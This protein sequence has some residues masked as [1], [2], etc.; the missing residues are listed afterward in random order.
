MRGFFCLAGSLLLC[1]CAPTSL[2]Q[3]SIAPAAV[4]PSPTPQFSAPDVPEIP[5]K[6]LSRK[7]RKELDSSL[8]PKVRQILEKAQSLEVLGLSSEE[9][10]G[11]GWHP[12]VSIGLP[13]SP[14]RRHLLESFYFDASAGP[15]PSACFLPRHG[16]KASYDG[17][18]VEIIICFQCH[19]FTVR[20][21]LGEFDGGVYLKG[22][23]SHHFFEKILREDRL[24][25]GVNS[26]SVSQF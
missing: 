21:D 5:V 20:G 22:S 2:N 6:A 26:N 14:E 17:K 24:K 8:P 18:T 7:Q 9:K 12:D 3:I 19:V 15:N 16:L 25:L 4:Y 11:I 1:G 13:N 10:V 23:A